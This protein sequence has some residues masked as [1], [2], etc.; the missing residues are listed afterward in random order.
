MQIILFFGTSLLVLLIIL[1]LA[2]HKLNPNR[3]KLT[4]AEMQQ[5]FDLLK[6]R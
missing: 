6:H 1:I 4:E 2:W 5:L 3:T